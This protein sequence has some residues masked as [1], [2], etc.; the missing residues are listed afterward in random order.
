MILL[1]KKNIPAREWVYNQ[2]CEAL[3]N[4]YGINNNTLSTVLKNDLEYLNELG[5]FPWLDPYDDDFDSEHITKIEEQLELAS[6]KHS[7]ATSL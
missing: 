7:H 1:V 4:Y 2:D 6:R 3:K 5:Y